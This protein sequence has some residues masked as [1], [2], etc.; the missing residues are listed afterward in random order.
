M[1]HAF[2]V[3]MGG[4]VVYNVPQQGQETTEGTYTLEVPRGKMITSLC[5]ILLSLNPR[6]LLHFTMATSNLAIVELHEM[7][8][9]ISEHEIKDLSKAD[10]ITKA[11]A[12]TQC[13]WLTVQCIARSAQ[14]YAISQ[15]E[16]GTLGFIFC[17]FIMHMFWWSKPFDI[18][19]R[20]VLPRLPLFGTPSHLQ[21]FLSMDDLTESNRELFKQRMS[22]L[23]DESPIDFVY[24][25]MQPGATLAQKLTSSTLY[26]TVIGFSVIHLLAW[27]WEFPAPLIQQLWRWFN[28]GA[29]AVSVLP[30][31]SL[32]ACHVLDPRD[33]IITS[34]GFG[35]FV[36]GVAIV[37]ALLRLGVLGL[38]FYCLSSMPERAYTTM[39]WLAWI[40]HFS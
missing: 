32:A 22:E 5:K 31:V 10:I 12:I 13:T 27:N 3:Q 38:T 4:I 30:V 18:E 21:L 9:E 25:I 35:M 20:R 2:Y 36:F 17:A 6:Q 16:L 26:L 11:F 15:L 19:S 33:V 8:V 29:A 24:D 7:E 34:D 14:G 28:L 39:D 23:E 1:A 40:P 37:Y